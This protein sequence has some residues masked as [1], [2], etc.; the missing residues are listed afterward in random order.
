MQTRSV[1][2]LLAG[3]VATAGGAAGAQTY[4]VEPGTTHLATALADA[5]SG[6]QMNGM[7]VTVR[8]SDGSTIGGTWGFLFDVMGVQH[9]GVSNALFTLSMRGDQA[10]RVS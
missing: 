8:F 1:L 3:A 6:S 7:L 4:D 2:A 10:V 5:V 9:Y